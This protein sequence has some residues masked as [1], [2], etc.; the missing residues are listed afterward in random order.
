MLLVVL[1]VALIGASISAAV[2]GTSRH[3]LPFG[4][5]S[6]SSTV[7]ADREAAMAATQQFVLRV[8]TYGPSLL[9][10][11]GQMPV[12]RSRVKAVITPKFAVSFD[13][14]VTVAEESV[15][16]YGVD[17]TCAVYA[18]G[19]EQIDA[20][21]AQVLVAGSFSETLKNK[22]GKRVS[23]GEPA[24]FRLRVS[25]DKIDGRWLVDDYQTV[26]S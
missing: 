21:S 15:K 4:G 9:D 20:D 10:A 18:T 12:Y 24:P 8:N 19:V 26:T 6:G 1:V 22:A 23:A 2:L 13:Q 17:R 7:Q 16:S 3:V 11:N 5:G 25:L 14:G